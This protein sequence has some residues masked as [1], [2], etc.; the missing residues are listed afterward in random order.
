MAANKLFVANFNFTVDDEKLKEFFSSVGTVASARVMREAEGGRSRGCG[1]VELGSAEEVERAISELDGS[2][3]DGRVIKVTHD[4]SGQQRTGQHGH[5]ADGD[6]DSYRNSGPI[7]YFR[8]QPLDIGIRKKKK[9]DPFLEDENLSVD[10]KDPKLLG[11]F[12]S[13]RGRILPRRMT[14]L[15]AYHQRKVSKAIKR[16]QELSIMPYTRA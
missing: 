4:T 3:W 11:K 16:A 2:I 15:T 12:T 7:G 1:F 14:G 13:E 9:M 10:Y 6:R 8:A 5:H